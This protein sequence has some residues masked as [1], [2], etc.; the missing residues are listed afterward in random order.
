[1]LKLVTFALVALSVEAAAPAG[2][3]GPQT[4][5]V[6]AVTP[7][8]HPAE[9]APDVAFWRRVYTEIDTGQGYLHDARFLGVVYE[10]LDV[11]E[12]SG[13]RQ[14]RKQVDAA[15]ARYREILRTLATGRREGLDA[16]HR[17]VLA[18]WPEEVTDTELSAAARRV[19]FQLGQADKFRAGLIRAGAWDSAIR[20]TLR[21]YG[22]PED[23]AIL[24]HVESS[25]D[26]SAHSHRGAAGIWQITR[27]TGRRYLRVD[28]VLDER[29][30]PLLAT[31]A[32]ARLL[33]HNL[34]LTGN[35]PLAITAYNHGASG[36]RR[37]VRVTGSDDI[38]TIVRDYSSRRFGFAS[39]NFYVA[40]LAARHVA[41]RASLYFG[42]L[43]PDA[44]FDDTVLAL[45]RFVPAR[46]VAAE[47]GIPLAELRRHNP[48]LRNSVWSGQQHIP[49]GYRLRVP[50]ER[51]DPE[52]TPRLL[53]RLH[54]GHGHDRQR[55]QREYTVEP[56]DTV[57][58][59]AERFGVSVRDLLDSNDLRNRHFIRVGQ[60]LRLPVEDPPGAIAG[61]APVAA[62]A[63]VAAAVPPVD[64]RYTVR[65]GDSLSSIAARF[66]ASEGALARWNALADADLIQAGRSLIVSGEVA[67][68]ATADDIAPIAAA[69][70][71]PPQ[72][73]AARVEPEPGDAPGEP[74][75]AAP[76][77]I[78]GNDPLDY[79]VADDDSVEIQLPETLGHLSQWLAVPTQRLRDLN[80]LRRGQTVWMG[81]RLRL[82]FSAVGRADFE[83]RRRAFHRRLQQSFFARH[84]V[85]GTHEHVIDPGDS[86]WLLA[87]QTYGLPL[88]LLLQFNPE[89]DF[90]KVRPGTRVIVPVIEKRPAVAPAPIS[91]G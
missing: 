21:D 8:P 22:L 91:A 36:V 31:D 49:R 81:H 7:F 53:A 67:P 26:P 17:R 15:R 6:D 5:P 1:M 50:R 38:A 82:D 27:P 28:R 89:L 20:A 84:R 42:E 45:E 60:V 47:L 64:G 51:L 4:P 14:R 48:A 35:W 32:A 86:L 74:L 87:E 16:E 41:A 85:A 80:D 46:A 75:A 76:R 68:G 11:G 23:L 72:A 29:R 43:V 24:P 13:R 65:P 55:R 83:R 30:D 62:P 9:L 44:P 54:A 37:A 52:A 78:Y 57:S 12:G 10:T 73:T 70:V 69:A 61:A 3:A 25:Y 34:Q 56:G 90:G 2:D 18:L 59:V 63:G 39:R 88:W 77:A 33:R 58:T 79:S 19:R 66:G 40:F 71:S